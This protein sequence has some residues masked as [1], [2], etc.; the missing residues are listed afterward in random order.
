MIL[1]S[2]NGREFSEAAINTQQS[3]LQGMLVLLSDNDIDEIITEWFVNLLGT[4]SPM[5]ELNERIA[6]FSTSLVHG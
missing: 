2:D 4:H 3:M 1:H 5:V 6:Q